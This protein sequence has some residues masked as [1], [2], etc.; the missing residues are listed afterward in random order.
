M[1]KAIKSEQLETQDFLLAEHENSTPVWVHCLLSQITDSS[2]QKNIEGV[3]FNVTTR[4]ETEIATKHEAAHDPLTGL[5][6]RQATQSLFENPPNKQNFCFLM[7]DLDGFKQANDTYGHLAGDQVLKITSDRLVQCVRSSDVICRLGGDEFLII[8]YNY[9]HQSLALE[10][11]EKIVLS[12]DKPMIINEDTIINVGISVGLTD[13]DLNENIDFENML[14]KADEAMY[15]VKQHG[16]NGYC[17]NNTKDE[18]FP[19]LL[20]TGFQSENPR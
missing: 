4:V 16:K 6:R 9:Q 10:I 14:K 7:M 18:M 3:L 17:I 2:G 15:V 19:K 8:L 13:S 5:L 1:D 12:I 11:A 20:K